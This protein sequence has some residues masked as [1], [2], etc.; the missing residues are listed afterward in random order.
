[1]AKDTKKLDILPDSAYVLGDLSP[2]ELQR[3]AWTTKRTCLITK[4]GPDH[5]P[6]YPEITGQGRALS[7]TLSAFFFSL[8]IGCRCCFGSVF[9]YF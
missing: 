2:E 4:T 6:G 8:A 3:Y 9:R 7:K 1:M 5:Q